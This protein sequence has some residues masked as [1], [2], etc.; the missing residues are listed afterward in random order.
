[1]SRSN[2]FVWTVC[3]VLLSFSTALAQGSATGGRGGHGSGPRNRGMNADMAGQAAG[4]QLNQNNAMSGMAMAQAMQ[5]QNQNQQNMP[6]VAQLAASMMSNY[7][8][9]NSGSLS[10]TELQAALTA[11]RSL[12]IANQANAGNNAFNQMNRR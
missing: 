6:T 4:N 2:T 1:M 10:L 11:L 3:F 9:D 8:T 7:D 12:L 5:A